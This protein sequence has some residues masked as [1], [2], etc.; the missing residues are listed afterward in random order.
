MFSE[1]NVEFSLRGLLFS[2]TQKRP[3]ESRRL[4][5]PFLQSFASA[6]HEIESVSRLNPSNLSPREGFLVQLPA[7]AAA[8]FHTEALQAF[9]SAI[10]ESISKSIFSR[11]TVMSQQRYQ[12]AAVTE[13]TRL[14]AKKRAP[15]QGRR[16]SVGR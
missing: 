4:F 2:I 5:L 14:Q 1:Q 8:S 10:S 15:K 9:V 12:V 16:K 6:K 3:K 11:S 13:K 7:C